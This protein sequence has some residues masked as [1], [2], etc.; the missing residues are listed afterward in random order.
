M[1]RWF[2][3]HLTRSLVN[4][5]LEDILQRIQV[6]IIIFD[7]HLVVWMIKS[8]LYLGEWLKN[9]MTLNVALPAFVKKASTLSHLA[10]NT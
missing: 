5:E 2:M 9:K 10:S 8:T 4:A 1:T 7:N 3:N 6:Y